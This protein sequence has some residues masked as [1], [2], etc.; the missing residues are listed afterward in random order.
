MSTKK[1][2]QPAEVMSHAD[3]STKDEGATPEST[4]T[5]AEAETAT[6]T[7]ADAGTTPATPEPPPPADDGTASEL[8]STVPEASV[9]TNAAN[10]PA[11]SEPPP[12][13]DEE[14]KPPLPALTVLILRDENIGGKD[15]RPGD[16]PKLPG[17]EVEALVA[18]KAGD[19]NAKAIAAAR[20]A[21]NV[22][23]KEEAVIE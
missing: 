7:A 16:T 10:T 21:R 20:K 22:S 3:E 14:P 18:R 5:G 15:Y 12:L 2:T 9:A 13:T 8:T 4:S 17:E 19:I 6:P 1:T 11:M 23:A